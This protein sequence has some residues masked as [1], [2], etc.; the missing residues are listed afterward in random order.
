MFKLGSTFACVNALQ[1]TCQT[2]ITVKFRR[3]YIYPCGNT[4]SSVLEAS[5][6]HL[7]R[8]ISVGINTTFF[9]LS[10]E[11]NFLP[12]KSRDNYVERASRTSGPCLGHIHVYRIFLLSTHRLR[13][14]YRIESL[15]LPGHPVTAA[16]LRTAIKET[17]CT[18]GTRSSYP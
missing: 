6:Y 17:H 10:L 12:C 18:L 8:N 7:Q 11:P 1:L 3:K 4:C 2:N 9:I 5:V 13:Q 15:H 16:V 14:F